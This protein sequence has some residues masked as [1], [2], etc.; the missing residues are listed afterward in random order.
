[1]LDFAKTRAN[2]SLNLDDGL[3]RTSRFI[4]AP[5]TVGFGASSPFPLAPAG[6]G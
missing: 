3:G 2:C 6:V 1:M 4:A 5:R